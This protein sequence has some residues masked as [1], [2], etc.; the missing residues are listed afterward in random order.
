M[1]KF[2]LDKMR[3]IKFAEKSEISG[4]IKNHPARTRAHYS[5]DLQK[6]GHPRIIAEIKKASPTMQARPVDPVRQ[7]ALYIEGGASAISVLTEKNYFSGSWQDLERVAQDVKVPLLCKEFIYYKEQ[8]DLAYLLGADLVLLIARS[9]SEQE[10]TTLYNYIK[11]K[12]LTPLIEIHAESELSKI[13]HLKPDLLMVNMRNLKTLELNIEKGIKALNAI[14]KNIL[15]ISA[16]AIKSP[17][18]IKSI[19]DKTGTELFLVGSA[20]MQSG[21]PVDFIR[22]LINVY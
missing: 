20:I 17:S 21:N 2:D 5:L 11:N 8:V 12:S 6:K 10:L 22:E 18:D 3:T 14:P 16:S 9:L 7:A 4:M 1:E 13:N 19:F 15:R